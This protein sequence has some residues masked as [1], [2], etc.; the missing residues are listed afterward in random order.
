LHSICTTTDAYVSTSGE[1]AVEEAG[2]NACE[3][4]VLVA[5][6]A[7]QVEAFTDTDWIRFLA[8]NYLLSGFVS[9]R[10]CY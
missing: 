6:E 9:R 8:Q 4:P 1:P 10:R 2:E 5:S 3:L 7:K